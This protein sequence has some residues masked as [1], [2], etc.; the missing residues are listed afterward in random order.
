MK[1]VAGI[2]VHQKIVMAVVVDASRPEERRD[3]DS[4]PCR[5]NCTVS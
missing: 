3:D 2:D 5:A 1:K 4:L